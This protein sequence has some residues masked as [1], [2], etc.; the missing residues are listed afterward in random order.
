MKRVPDV[1]ITSYTQ[2]IQEFDEEFYRQFQIVI[3]GLDNIEARRWINSMLHSLVEFDSKETPLIETQRP[4]IDGGTEGFKGQARVIVPFKTGCFECS[5]GSLPKQTGFPMCT[6]RET[7]RLPEHCIQYAYVIS[8][9]EHFGKKAV[10]KDSYEDMQWIYLKALERGESYGIQGVTYH[11]TMGVVKNIIPAIAST[12]ALISAACVTECL[13][14]L[15]SCNFNMN[16]YMMY[17]G[18][19]GIYTNTFEYARED[20][21]KFRLTIIDNRTAGFAKRNRSFKLTK[22]KHCK[23][24]LIG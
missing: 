4:L 16:N 8:W 6:I 12:N 23:I 18:Q 17:M 20:V 3:A 14:F 24:F 22:T 19:T 21:R 10:D 11:L 15:S 9:E 5:L 7:P 2:P 13:K 1:K